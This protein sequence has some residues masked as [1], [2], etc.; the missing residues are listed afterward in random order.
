MVPSFGRI[1]PVS[2]SGFKWRDETSISTLFT[3]VGGIP[4]GRLSGCDVY[5]YQE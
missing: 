1:S 3:D 4:K 5:I 2:G